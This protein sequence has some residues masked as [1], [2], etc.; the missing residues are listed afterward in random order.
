MQHAGRGEGGGG[1]T[2][3]CEVRPTAGQIHEGYTS[4]PSPA[5]GRECLLVWNMAPGARRFLDKDVASR[6]ASFLFLGSFSSCAMA[7][8]QKQTE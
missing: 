8:Q 1:R 3:S 7:D 6:Q 2:M 4:L 5:A